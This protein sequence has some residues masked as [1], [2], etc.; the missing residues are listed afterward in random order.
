[1]TAGA[2]K[3]N[4]NAEKWDFE[5]AEQFLESAVEL[6]ENEDY[7]F[8]GEVAKDLKQGKNTFDY[9]AGKFPALN[10]YR[11]IIKNNCETNCFR[12]SKKGNIREATAIINL[13]ANHGWK[14]RSDLTTNDKEINIPPT[15]WLNEPTK[16]TPE[17]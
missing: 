13:K 8:I 16:D 15:H 1:M 4:T 2:P 14:D 11:T 10:H 5:T 12:N 7:D 9:L 17:I 6:S 3:Y